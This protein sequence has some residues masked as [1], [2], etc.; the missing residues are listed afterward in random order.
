MIVELENMLCIKCGGHFAAKIDREILL[1]PYCGRRILAT[2][3]VGDYSELNGA[4]TEKPAY[5]AIKSDFSQ[6]ED[7]KEFE[8]VG[9]TLKK[10]HGDGE[11]VIIPSEVKV[12]G[13]SCFFGNAKIKKVVLHDGVKRIEN[14]A[15]DGCKS[16]TEI[17][18][19][20]GLETVGA[21]AFKG[22]GLKAVDIPGSVQLIGDDAF[23]GCAALLSAKLGAGVKAIGARAFYECRRLKRVEFPATL[24][25]I[26]RLAFAGDA[27]L[28][29]L[30]LPHSLEF[31]DDNAFSGCVSLG[32]A[33]LPLSLKQIGKTLFD[34]CGIKKISMSKIFNVNCL[35]CGQT[36]V[37]V[38]SGKCRVCGCEY[39]YTDDLIKSRPIRRKSDKNK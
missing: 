13:T 12:I 31:I 8:I 26:G 9:E 14:I 35:S 33:A 38:F 7:E 23:S 11:T 30:K 25:T 22:C 32:K 29:S 28:E 17:N 19:P 37:P 16:L 15:F 36:T 27:E 21:L 18:L 4:K 1:C 10:Y 24:I 5:S 6:N 34:D 3:A 39:E 20:M 2:E